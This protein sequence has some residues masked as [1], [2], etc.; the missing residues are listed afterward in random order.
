[1]GQETFDGVGNVT[2]VRDENSDGVVTSA[3]PF[4]G[5]YTVDADGLGRGEIALG[6]VQQ[7]F[8]LASPRRGFIVDTSDYD[9]GMFE[10]QSGAPF[11]DVSISGNL[12]LGT[13]PWPFNWTF[14][15]ASGV[16]SATGSNGLLGTSDCV[17]GSDSSFSGIYS[18]SG[19]G[20]TTMTITPDSGSPSNWVFYLSSP[21]KAA[22]IDVDGGTANSAIRIIEK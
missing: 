18:V 3:Q 15:P 6:G 1:V 7:S 5:T 13:L 4:S 19:N 20:R 10:V 22:G 9:E 14:S 17:C 16:M 2:G 11:S 21:S 12:V 8:Y